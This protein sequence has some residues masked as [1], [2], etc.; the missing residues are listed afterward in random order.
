MMC[1]VMPTISEDSISQR[2]SQFS[3]E[4]G[5]FEQ[6][7]VTMLD[8]RDKLVDSLRETQD[9]LGETES[10]L[11][12]VE[13]ERDS[14]QRQISANLP[15]VCTSCIYYYQPFRLPPL[16]LIWSFIDSLIVVLDRHIIS[17]SH[18][19]EEKNKY[20]ETC[21]LFFFKFELNQYY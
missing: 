21:K 14:L 9:R 5:N 1:D 11:I 12:E 10:K 6:L 18:Y 8:Q 17:V 16:H 15:Q 4:D 3:G 20:F 13:K 7:M 19:N 2:S